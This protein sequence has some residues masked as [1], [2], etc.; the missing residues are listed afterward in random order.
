MK[1][2]KIYINIRFII[3]KQ[4]WKK[5]IE[6]IAAHTHIADAVYIP[7]NYSSCLAIVALFI[8]AF[9]HFF[10]IVTLFVSF[11]NYRN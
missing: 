3:S 7:W 5:L 2:L 9:F 4:H 8:S 10:R 11:I 6:H 1:M